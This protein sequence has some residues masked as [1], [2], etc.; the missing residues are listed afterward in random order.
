MQAQT[1]ASP[2][3]HEFPIIYTPLSST[4]PIHTQESSQ[5]WQNPTPYYTEDKHS[6]SS[7]TSGCN[8]N[9][10]RDRSSQRQYSIHYHW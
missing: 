1:E 6:S 2:T 9:E 10:I 5:S 7:T 4:S 8:L 3:R